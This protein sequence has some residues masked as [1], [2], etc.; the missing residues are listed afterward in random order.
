MQTYAEKSRWSYAENSSSDCCGIALSFLL[1]EEWASVSIS[2]VYHTTSGSLSSRSLFSSQPS[3]ASVFS[4]LT[5][6]AHPVGIGSGRHLCDSPRAGL[7][8]ALERD[9]KN[10]IGFDPQQTTGRHL[11]HACQE[12]S[13]GVPAVANDHRAQTT[14]HQQIDNGCQLTILRKRFGPLTNNFPVVAV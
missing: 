13:A 4:T 6:I 11:A 2:S 10:A 8:F 1:G 5:L 7:A 9:E 12:W 3:D 14:L